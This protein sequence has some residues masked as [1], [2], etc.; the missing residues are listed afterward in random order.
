MCIRILKKINSLHFRT[1]IVKHIQIHSLN[2]DFD[3]GEVYLPKQTN[4]Q[5]PLKFIK[6]HGLLQEVFWT[7]FCVLLPRSLLSIE[8]QPNL[9]FKIYGILIP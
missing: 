4:K 9:N 7:L 6:S 8:F 2:K 1:V 3:Y 5:I